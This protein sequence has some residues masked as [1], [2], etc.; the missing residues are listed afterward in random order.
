[1]VIVA[2]ETV[3]RHGSV[4]L[5]DNG[6]CHARTGD[7]TRTHGER[8]PADIHDWLAA[9]DRQLADVDVLAVVIG[10]GSFTGLR[11]GIAAIQGLAV[12]SAR[13]VVGVPT[14]DALAEAWLMVPAFPDAIVVA[15]L[16]GQRGE[17]FLA[18]WDAFGAGSVE[19]AVPIVPPSITRPESVAEVLATVPSD[20]RIV[21]VGD[22]TE[23]HA[24]ILKRALP[25]A[26]VT[27]AP[28]PLAEAAAW[29]ASRRPETAGAPHALRPI[30]LRRPDAELARERAI[31]ARPLRDEVIVR[32]AGSPEDMAAVA[33]LQRET[34][35]N[36]WG[37]ESIRWELEHTDVARLYVVQTRG[38]EL[39]AYCAC[40]MVFDEL[41]LNSLAVAA[42]HR[43]QGMA[44][45]LLEHV[46][47]EAVDAGAS[48][49]TLEV[50]SSNEAARRLYDALGF[51]VEGL[52]RDYYQDPRE[53][54]VILWRRAL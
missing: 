13:P 16:D 2:L 44:R 54:A 48:A 18:A 50:R 7:P 26:H 22:A 19:R 42:G 41:H 51:R 53:D 31:R 52:R 47:R 43:R 15:C 9:H 25:D 33:A 30:Y 3:T 4:A 35:S 10:P 21:L 6:V 14:L 29:L 37:A 45:L 24:E 34:F 40:W 27:G 36:P 20:R 11:V 28:V 12:A 38:G 39:V 8:L 17:V 49:A 46:L 5:W 1:M 32:R 23:R